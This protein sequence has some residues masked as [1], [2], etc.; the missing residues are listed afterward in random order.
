MRLIPHNQEIH[1]EDATCY[2]E[3]VGSHEWQ[4]VF[5]DLKKGAPHKTREGARLHIRSLK[6]PQ[7]T[8]FDR[9]VAGMNT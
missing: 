8:R 5:H 9:I 2:I 1:S 6:H 7:E 3:R 4:V